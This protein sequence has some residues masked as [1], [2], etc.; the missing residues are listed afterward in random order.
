MIFIKKKRNVK[1]RYQVLIAVNS[2]KGSRA[3]NVHILLHGLWHNSSILLLV[4]SISVIL[5]QF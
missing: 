2:K 5:K 4:C 3:R 1:D